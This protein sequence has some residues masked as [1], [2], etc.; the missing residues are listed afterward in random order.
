MEQTK[1]KSL[2]ENLIKE[3]EKNSDLTIDEIIQKLSLEMQMNKLITDV[4]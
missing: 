2:L 1:L 4:N 3:I